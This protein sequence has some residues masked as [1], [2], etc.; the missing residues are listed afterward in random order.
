VEITRLSSKGQIIIPKAVRENHFW[1]AGTRFLIEETQAG[2]LLKP[3][4]GFP[5]T[6]LQ[7]GLGCTHYQGPPKSL[8]DISR[9]IDAELKRLWQ[10]EPAP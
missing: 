2:I 6:N 4:S 5:E 7:H 1:K 8:E 3:V 10:G 9:S